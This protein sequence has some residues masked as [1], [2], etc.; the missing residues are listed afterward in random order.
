MKKHIPNFITLLNLLSGLVA[1]IFALKGDLAFASFFILLGIL[2]DFFDGFAARLLNVSGELGKQLDSLA[3][4]TTSGAAPAMIMYKLLEQSQEQTA[5]YQ[6]FSSAVGSWLPTDDTAI[7]YFP[8]I[9][10]LIA[11]A[12]VYRLAKFNIDTRQTSSFIGLPTPAAALII[13]ALPLIQ[14]YSDNAL[15]LNL[16]QN[17]FVLIG[18]TIFLSVLMNTEL[19]LFSLKFKN[20]AFKDNVF[21]YLFLIISIILIVLFQFVAIPLIIT[22]YIIMS[23]IMNL[24]K[25]NN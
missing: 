4:A 2:F 6:E 3:D 19:P 16:T 25:A 9:G 7:Y 13:A 10:L 23:A 1:I 24:T 12:A 11:L 20:Y 8:F 15:A 21:V 22:L 5:W 17:K 18:I 14:V